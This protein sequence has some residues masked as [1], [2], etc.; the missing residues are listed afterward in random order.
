VSTAA[1]AD[2]R[3]LARALGAATFGLALG[4]L[5]LAR[6]G[7]SAAVPGPAARRRLPLAPDDTGREHTDRA[8][9]QATATIGCSDVGTDTAGNDRATAALQARRLYQAAAM[10]A[11]S[12]LSDSALEHYRGNFEN[13]GMFTPLASAAVLLACALRGASRDT[14]KAAR[15]RGRAPDHA[16]VPARRTNRADDA[17]LATTARYATTR[18]PGPAA[19]VPYA[20]ACAVGAAGL[21]FHAYNVLRRPGGLSWANLFYAAPLGAP[22]ALLLAG[23]I[24]LAAR[25]VAAGA[26]T[27]AGL[28]S[29]RALCGLAAFGLAGT[30]AE[31]AL[32][33]FRGAF[34]HPAMWVPVSVPPVTAAMLAGAALP[35]ATRPRPL[36]NALLRACTWLGMLGMGF[37]A[38][39]I[40]RQM[41]GWRNWSQN[42]LAGP[43][44]PAPPSFSAL[45]LAGRAALALRATQ[46]GPHRGAA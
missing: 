19:T 10:L 20:T 7:P 1:P 45:A 9:A 44:L 15:A 31:A 23:V 36:T 18:A 4:A 35:G 28:P 27:L 43:P 21:G 41:G 30:S 8:P 5:L 11:A 37:H 25:P 33:H 46:A 24:G 40:A 29:G 14:G 42:I 3:P 2:A 22:A 16:R 26:P 34:Q 13:P 39:G 12:V 38:R 6:R 32:L 17:Q